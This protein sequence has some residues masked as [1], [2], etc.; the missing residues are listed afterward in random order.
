MGKNKA[1]LKKDKTFLLVM[2]CPEGEKATNITSMID[3]FT[4]NSVKEI[5][6]SAQFD[7]NWDIDIN[8]IYFNISFEIYSYKTKIIYQFIK[9]IWNIHS[10]FNLL[11]FYIKNKE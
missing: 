1:L 3:I 11:D 9:K 2:I 6:V 5:S 4:W 10:P 7:W 8:L